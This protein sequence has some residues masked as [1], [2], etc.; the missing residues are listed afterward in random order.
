M[1]K[2]Y[3][4]LIFVLII[5]VAVIFVFIKKYNTTENINKR[6]INFCIKN[7]NEY[8]KIFNSDGTIDYICI[9][10]GAKINVIEYYK[11]KK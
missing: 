3:K 11:N 6:A 10:N 9:V 1:K 4:I 2:H 7:N 5:L 8:R